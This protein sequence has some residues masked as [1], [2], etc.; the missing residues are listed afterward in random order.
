ME[1]REDQGDNDLSDYQ[2]ADLKWEFEKH[3]DNFRFFLDLALKAVGLFYVV[4]GGILSIYFAKEPNK[5][6]EVVKFLL[7]APFT[8]PNK[9]LQLTAR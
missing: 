8:A 9:V 1:T 6:H 7:W 2:K 5:N 4:V 3:L